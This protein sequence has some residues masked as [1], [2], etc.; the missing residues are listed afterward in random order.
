M[1][2]KI[3]ILSYE[4][5]LVQE[6][7]YAH[8]KNGN[9]VD[10]NQASTGWGPQKIIIDP[11]HPEHIQALLHELTHCADRYWYSRLT[12]QQVLAISEGLYHILTENGVDLSVLTRE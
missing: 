6:H 1:S 2:K 8:N 3:K 11:E 4:F 7:G 5:E 12:E 10:C 9:N